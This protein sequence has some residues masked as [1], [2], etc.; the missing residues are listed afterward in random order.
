M[1]DITPDSTDVFLG[2]LEEQLAARGERFELV[3]IGGAGLQALGVIQRSTRD[4]DIIALRAGEDLT[5]AEPLPDGLEAA[6]DLVARDFQLST[7]WLNPG[8]TDMLDLGIPDGF[9]D[10]LERRD[11][12]EALTI[13][14]ASRYDQIHFKFYAAVDS[15]GPGKHEKDLWALEPTEAELLDA[16]RWSCTHDISP[17]HAETVRRA[18]EFFGVKDVDLG[19]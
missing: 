3:V 2:A 8:P 12:G 6:R 10:R 15:R 11:Y 1:S 4:I 5:K 17:A 13:Y 14:L 18:L 19:T 9:I 7:D 16:A